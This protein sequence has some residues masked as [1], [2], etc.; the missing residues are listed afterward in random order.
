MKG[1][2]KAR[3]DQDRR[4]RMGKNRKGGRRK[5]VVQMLTFSKGER[6]EMER[7]RG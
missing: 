7:N 1:G 6:R 3:E 2:E 5:D 4:R